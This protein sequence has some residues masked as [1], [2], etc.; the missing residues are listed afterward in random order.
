MENLEK[1]PGDADN[2]KVAEG[3]LSKFLKSD[4][5][6]LAELAHLLDKAGVTSAT[7][8][9]NVRG[10]GNIV[11]Q[12][13]GPGSVTINAGAARAGRPPKAR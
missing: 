5:A 6:A 8:I 10:D 2:R 11:A 4:P 13:A 9:A 3:L 7:Q 12:N 1:D